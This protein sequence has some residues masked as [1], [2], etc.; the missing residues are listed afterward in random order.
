MNDIDLSLFTV[1]HYPKSPAGQGMNPRAVR[2]LEKRGL[3]VDTCLRQ[4][5]ILN[6]KYALDGI[7]FEPGATLTAG[8]HA[9]AFL[10]QTITGLNSAVP[11]ETNVQGQFRRA[12][13]KC[14]VDAEP[15]LFASLSGIIHKAFN[16]SREI[17]RNYLQG[18]GGQSYGSLARKLIAPDEGSRI[19]FVGTGDLARSM[20]PLFGNYALAAW[21]HRATRTTLGDVRVFRPNEAAK[22]AAW[23]SHIVMTTPADDAHD[24]FWAGLSAGLSTNRIEAIVHLG[25]RRAERGCWEH[26]SQGKRYYD[27]DD[28]FALRESQSVLRAL[29]ILRARKACQHFAAADAEPDTHAASLLPQRA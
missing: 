16:H 13:E 24:A 5:A 8:N 9:Y 7:D 29:N 2:K 10:L 1:I 26:W 3:F 22:A 15:A 12:W 20:L 19:L 23:A 28:V 27:L 14:R 11:G 21:N 25:R 18:I 6:R 4:L 17:R